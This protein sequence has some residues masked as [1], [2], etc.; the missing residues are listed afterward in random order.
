M[1]DEIG[2]PG[3]A[4]RSP[5]SGLHA[6]GGFGL[7]L[8]AIQGLN[9]KTEAESQRAEARSRR[10]EAWIRRLEAENKEL[11]ARLERLERLL[12]EKRSE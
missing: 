3:F 1:L 2:R 7:S 9:G 5:A 11:K 4:L 8:A 10:S 6:R 12:G